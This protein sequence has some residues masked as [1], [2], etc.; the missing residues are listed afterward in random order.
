MFRDT[1]TIR[2]NVVAIWALLEALER[3]STY[4]T[5]Q[6]STANRYF[7]NMLLPGLLQL[8]LDPSVST[9]KIG[10]TMP[11][12]VTAG[13]PSVPLI[14]HVQHLQL[15][16]PSETLH[17]TQSLSFSVRQT[18]VPGKEGHPYHCHTQWLVLWISSSP[19]L[20]TQVRPLFRCPTSNL[21]PRIHFSLQIVLPSMIS[22]LLFAFCA[23]HNHG[24]HSQSAL[25]A[26][27]ASSRPSLKSS[28]RVHCPMSSCS[29]S[30]QHGPAAQ[31]RR[32]S[33]WPS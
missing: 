6:I 26:S 23:N 16:E 28:P 15:T 30:S 4:H 33:R 13:C 1:G 2:N 22:N 19:L 3:Q 11:F 31:R 24:G 27:S 20:P 14:P 10:S 8:N 9:R 29:P 18:S 21:F 5:A 17:P 7:W 12:S 25:S 32:S